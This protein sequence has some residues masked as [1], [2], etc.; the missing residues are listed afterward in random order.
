MELA[1]PCLTC[2][3][4]VSKNKH[5]KKP[6]S[7]CCVKSLK[8]SGGQLADRIPSLSFN[9]AEAHMLSQSPASLL[10]LQDEWGIFKVKALL[11]L[12]LPAISLPVHDI[13]DV[14]QTP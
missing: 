8:H 5:N 1:E 2:Q 13:I 3:N 11:Q 9:H 14:R 4:D 6:A 7:V 10:S 12:C